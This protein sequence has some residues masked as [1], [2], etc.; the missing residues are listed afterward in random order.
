MASIIEEYMNIILQIENLLKNEE[1]TILR[2]EKEEDEIMRKIKVFYHC[3]VNVYKEINK[4][5]NDLRKNINKWIKDLKFRKITID[6]IDYIIANFR[7][8]YGVRKK[9]VSEKCHYCL[10]VLKEGIQL[11]VKLP[12]IYVEEENEFGGIENEFR[13]IEK[14]VRKV[15][16]NLEKFHYII[17]KA[18]KEI[19]NEYI[20]ELKK[21]EKKL[22][23]LHKLLQ[24]Y[25]NVASKI[26]D[27]L[28]VLR[29]NVYHAIKSI[30]YEKSMAIPIEVSMEKASYHAAPVLKIRMRYIEFPSDTE[31]CK[32]YPIPMEALER[33]EIPT[34]LEIYKLQHLIL[35]IWNILNEI[36]EEE[37]FLAR[38]KE[39]FKKEIR[40][41]VELERKKNI[42]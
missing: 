4:N 14:F 21:D 27:K 7:K 8:V 38:L 30:L 20:M 42:K 28:L 40:Q 9:L 34:P 12:Y 2:I 17:W 25:T 6:P 24:E 19:I 29:N 33:G 11:L 18:R 32:E 10:K 3:L 37:V 31:F 35:F 15:L 5:W 22:K 13:K 23:K 39:V 26:E 1:K 41:I 36:K 16:D